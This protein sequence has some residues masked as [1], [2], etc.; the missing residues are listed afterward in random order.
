MPARRALTA[1][2]L[3]GAAAGAQETQ[4]LIDRPLTLPRGAVDLTLHGT[5][6]NFG[7]GATGAASATGETLALGVDFGASDQAQLGFG[8][9]LPINP[10]AG[11]GSIMASAA[12][13][14]SPRAALRVDAGFESIGAN[15]NNAGFPGHISRYFV[16]LGPRI[17][18]PLSPTLAFVT[19]RIGAVQFGHFNNV[20]DNGT[21]F[22]F[23]AS[24]LSQASSDF[25]VFSA[26][27][28]N[29]NTIIG[30]N[31]PAGLLL[32]AA[33]GLAVTFLAG[34]SGSISMP[35]SG[36][37]QSL[38]F[39]PIGFEALVTPAPSLDFGMRFSFDGYVA[40]T[41]SVASSPGY[42]DWR[43]LMLWFRIRA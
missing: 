13:G 27:N 32:Q 6:T 25:F 22:Y 17:K 23:G 4:P 12:L 3:C 14:V 10:G 9:A 1:L 18:V 38:H 2:F 11:F 42:F 33:P 16:G 43:E 20:G 24:G 7:S 40:H 34:Y 30:F 21:G 5:Y 28:N 41:G 37:T 35:Q 19:G 29:S 8:L 26:G 39:I 36:S 31:L 15:G